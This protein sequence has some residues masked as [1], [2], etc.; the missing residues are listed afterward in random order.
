MLQRAALISSRDGW[1][2]SSIGCA[3]WVRPLQAC[4]KPSLLLH[5]VAWVLWGPRAVALHGRLD[6]G[7]LL[8]AVQMHRA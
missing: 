2:L 7:A 4:W 6:R 8:S 3:G 1:M 5:K